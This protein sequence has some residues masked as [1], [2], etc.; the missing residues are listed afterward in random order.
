MIWE[1]QAP[2]IE[3]GI[4]QQQLPEKRGVE[5]PFS[6]FYMVLHHLSVE[7]LQT[8]RTKST[9]T[10]QQSLVSRIAIPCDPLDPLNTCLCKSWA[11]PT[12]EGL[13]GYGIH[14]VHHML[15]KV[16]L[17]VW[18]KKI[19]KWEIVQHVWLLEVNMY[20]QHIYQRFHIAMENGPFIDDV[21]Y[22]LTKDADFP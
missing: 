16:L 15:S 9:T 8:W 14:H 19:Y 12:S 11:T 17:E 21:L 18:W 13:N 10:L 20:F 3:D 6:R 22:L 1:I 4:P 2:D 5:I 7:H